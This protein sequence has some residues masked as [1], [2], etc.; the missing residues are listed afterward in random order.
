MFYNRAAEKI[1]NGTKALDIL[2]GY[3][4]R[5]GSFGAMTTAT[6]S[7][8]VDFASSDHEAAKSITARTSKSE[9]YS[10]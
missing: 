4:T 3:Y 10:I 1:E 7:R 6:P 8:L 5:S 9:Q 2:D